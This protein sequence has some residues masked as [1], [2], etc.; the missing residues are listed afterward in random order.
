VSAKF[1]REPEDP[2][3]TYWA[4]EA[5]GQQLA[6]LD[7]RSGVAEVARRRPAGEHAGKLGAARRHELG[8]RGRERA[9][10]EAGQPIELETVDHSLCKEGEKTTNVSGS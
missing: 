3:E 8:C 7:A 10:G 9:R 1:E 5:H 6:S 2:K 4:L